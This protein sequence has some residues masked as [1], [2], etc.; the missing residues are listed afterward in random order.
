[1][2]DFLPIPP[3]QEPLAPG[4]PFCGASPTARGGAAAG[5]N[6]G[7]QPSPFRQMVTP[8]GYTMS[9]AMTN[10]GDWAGPPIC[11]AISM[12]RRSANRQP[13]PPMPPI[14]RTG[15]EGGAAGG[16]PDFPPMPV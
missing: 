14:S 8:G 6:A 2:L 11:T 3:W 15:A 9:V 16:Y 10:C 13:W 4:P 12:P 5:D 1:M 7:R